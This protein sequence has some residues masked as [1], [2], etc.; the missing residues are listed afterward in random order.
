M[1]LCRPATMRNSF[2]HIAFE[3]KQANRDSVQ[4]NF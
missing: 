2:V 3:V 4:K 1:A